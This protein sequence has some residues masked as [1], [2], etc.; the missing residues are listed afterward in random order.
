VAS[1]FIMNLARSI[2]IHP[3]PSFN[4][5]PGVK[6]LVSRPVL[7]VFCMPGSAVAKAVVVPWR[8][9]CRDLDIE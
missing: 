1:A 2:L 8:K 6:Y 5:F 4:V 7:R 3:I 9:T